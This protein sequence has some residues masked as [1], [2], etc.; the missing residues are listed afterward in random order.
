MTR[1]ETTDGVSHVNEA[2]RQAHGFSSFFGD[3]VNW[4]KNAF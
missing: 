4:Q 2:I 1:I 3:F